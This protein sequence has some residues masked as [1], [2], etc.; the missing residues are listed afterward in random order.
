MT[1][2]IAVMN[3]RAVALA[4]DSAVTLIDGGTVVVRNDQR[5]LYNLINGQPIGVMFFGVADMMGH[6]WEHLIEHYQTKMRPGPHAHIRDYASGFLGMIDHLE[7]F[8]PKDRQK[9]DYKRLLASVF[10][11]IFHMAQYLRESGGAAR[12]NVADTAILEEAIERVWRDYQFREDGSPRSDL[13]CFP[14]G[15]AG[16][17]ARDHSAEIDELITY[18]FQPFGLG[19][20]ANARLKDIAVFCVVKDLFLEDVTGL[21]FAG[22]GT[23]ERYP[24]VATYFVSSIV[25]GI[26]KRAEASFDHPR[27][28]PFDRIGLTAETLVRAATGNLAADAA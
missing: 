20:Q 26:A 10:R 27:H 16:H 1:S 17:V 11:Y 9:D 5:K 13:T 3:Q 18:G 24:V 28:E 21:V 19:K 22:F 14:K 12:A 15:F 7:E 6:P 8:F 2:E 4:A 23:E 25:G